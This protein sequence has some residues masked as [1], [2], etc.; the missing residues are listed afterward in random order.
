MWVFLLTE[1]MFFVGMFMAYLAY[2]QIYPDS[3]AA[4]SSKLNVTLG[5]CNTLVLIGSS[6]TMGLAGRRGAAGRGGEVSLF[7]SGFVRGRELETQRH[8]GDV[9]YPGADRQFADHGAGGSQCGSG[10]R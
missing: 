3:F 5:M 9:Q 2:R 8:P 10:Q 1:I 4:A 7:R 6:L